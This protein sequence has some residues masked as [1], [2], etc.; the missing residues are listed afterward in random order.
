[1]IKAKAKLQNSNDSMFSIAE[2]AGYASEAAFGKA[3]KKHFNTTPGK[4]R[5]QP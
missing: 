4:L 5:R 2:T 1:L 3:I